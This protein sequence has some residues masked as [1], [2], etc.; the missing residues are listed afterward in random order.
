M[1][2]LF[3]RPGA[4]NVCV[5]A[6][7]AEV[8]ATCELI[9]LDRDAEGRLPESLRAFNPM[10]QV[11]TLV[12]PDGSIMTE[13]AAILI[14]LGDLYP[15]ANLAPAVT[16][17]ERPQYLR[18]MVFMASA[19]YVSNLRLFYPQ[20]FTTDPA[21]HEAVKAKAATNLDS[22]YA[23][24]ATGLGSKSYLLGNS[25]TAADIYAAMLI[26]WGPDMAA[27]AQKH[28]NLKSLHDRVAQ[29]PLIAPVWARNNMS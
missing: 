6:M 21:G 2:K 4:G 20:Q 28:P 24:L 23:I 18:W 8:G 27:L 29:R 14:Y 25:L 17:P 7:L 12:M 9:P 19:L 26:Q 11:P 10:M 3:T 22:E 13:S 5:E 15:Q 1:F 16:A